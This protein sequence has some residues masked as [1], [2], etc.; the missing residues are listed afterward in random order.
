[1]NLTT[2]AHVTVPKTKG[3]SA[4][5]AKPRS[6]WKAIHPIQPT[7]ITSTK[8]HVAQGRLASVSGKGDRPTGYYWWV[9]FLE[10]F[11]KMFEMNPD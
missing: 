7:P 6:V 4:F 5:V 9:S 1:M 10:T 3:P 11:K 2:G 8:C